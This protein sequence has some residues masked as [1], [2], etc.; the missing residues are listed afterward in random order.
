MKS[1]FEKIRELNQNMKLKQRMIVVYA[2]GCFLP[3]FVVF[4][5]MFHQINVSLRNNHLNEQENALNTQKEVLEGSM[6]MAAELSSRFYFDK[7]SKK[8]AIT[9]YAD[10]GDLKCD[11]RNFEKLYEYIDSYY[12][13]ISAISVYLYDENIKMDNR[14]FKF[15]TDTIKEK[16]WY[17]S[18]IAIN[19]VPRWSYLTNVQT[20]QKSLRMTRTLYDGTGRIVGILSIALDPELSEDYIMNHSSNAI[21]LKDDEEKVYAN[22]DLDEEDQGLILFQTGRKDFSGNIT[23]HG[24]EYLTTRINISSRYTDDYYSIILMTSDAGLKSETA[25]SAVLLMLP[26]LAAGIIMAL[27]ILLFNVWFGRRIVAIT[28]AMKNVTEKDKESADR[29]I[30]SAKDE[31]WELYNDLDEMVSEMQRLDAE[32]ANERVQKEQMYSRQRDMEFKMLAT[33]INPHFLY[34]TLEN[35]RMLASINKQKEIEEISVDLTSLLRSSLEV[36]KELRSLA[37]EMDKV[38]RYIRIQDYRFGDRIEASLEYDKEEAEKYMVI[39]FIVQPLVENAYVHGMEAMESGKIQV[40]AEVN[41]EQEILLITIKDDGMGMTE[42]QQ[43]A[44]REDMKNLE[45][46]DRTH[47]GIANVNQRIKLRFGEDF[48]VTFSSSP[49]NGTEI[50]IKI[51]LI[52]R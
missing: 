3:L 25:R 41:K 52:Q 38:E 34:N 37:W 29:A 26:L 4:I 12:Q 5:I 16:D 35:I 44:L 46:I 27:A 40:K 10:E 33:Q 31:I 1:F 30:G 39:P 51:P 50:C 15:I 6:D 19:G 23:L 17:K 8:L 24:D 21:M 32:A 18:T 13:N 42:E 49:G 28:D 2:I 9:R 7:N 43:K 47:I 20:G 11:Y 45:D 48:G 14:H 36:G 22:F